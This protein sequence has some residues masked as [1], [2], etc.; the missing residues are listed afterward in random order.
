M[1]ARDG[2]GRSEAARLAPPAAS[3][4]AAAQLPI[5]LILLRQAA[6]YLSLPVF[7]VDAAGRLVYFNDPAE[8]LLGLRFE[9][10]GELEMTDWL[11]AFRPGDEAGRPFEPEEV[12]LVA[13]LRD[14]RPVHARLTIVG[15]DGSRRAIEASCLPLRGQAGGLLG[16]IA[17]FW[18]PQ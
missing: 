12:P 9:E 13:A 4:A 6:S 17:W 16:A 7:L 2:R 3:E 14:A 11:G 18:A 15:H 8:P 1:S 10:V 5:E